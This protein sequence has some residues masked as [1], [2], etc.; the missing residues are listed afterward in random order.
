M[1]Q[2]RVH[3]RE[4]KRQRHEG[5]ETLMAFYNKVIVLDTESTV[6]VVD[7]G[8]SLETKGHLYI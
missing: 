6:D 2:E 8:E 3:S 7:E 5:A 1:R 4:L